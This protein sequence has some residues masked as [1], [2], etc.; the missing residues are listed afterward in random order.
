MYVNVNLLKSR[1]LSLHEFAV[2]S[3]LRQNKFENNVD[4]LEKECNIDVLKKF[5]DLGLI[6]Q[7]KRKNKSQNE[8]ELI[9][10]T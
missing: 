6:E 8:L 7:V 9:R 5:N 2:L 3:L 10:T 4:L 1:N